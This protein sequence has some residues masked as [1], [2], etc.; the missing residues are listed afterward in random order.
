MNDIDIK[1]NINAKQKAMIVSVVVFLCAII[2]ATYAWISHDFFGVSNNMSVTSVGLQLNFRGTSPQIIADLAPGES[3][4][5]TFQITNLGVAS[6]TVNIYWKNVVNTFPDNHYFMYVLTNADTDEVL[7]SAKYLPVSQ[8][9]ITY[10]SIVPG[11]TTINYNL[12]IT[13]I[14]DPFYD[15]T[16][17]A[18]Y[19]FWG[20]IS[21][22]ARN[23]NLTLSDKLNIYIDGV[24]TDETPDYSDYILDY[25]NSYCT[26]GSSFT[27]TNNEIQL[28][29]ELPSTM[30]SIYLSSTELE[31]SNKEAFN[32]LVI[33]TDTNQFDS[34]TNY[35]YEGEVINL[36]IPERE[37]YA[38]MGW[39]I[40]GNNAELIDNTKIKVGSTYT[41]VKGALLPGYW[42]ER[43]NLCLRNAP[44]TFNRTYKTCESSE[45]GFT[46]TTKT[47]MVSEYKIDTKTCS[48]VT[49]ERK[50]THTCIG[51]RTGYSGTCVGPK[52]V[53]GATSTS[54]CPCGGDNCDRLDGRDCCY[55]GTTTKSCTSSSCPSGYSGTCTS[56]YS[57]SWNSSSTTV[58]SNSCHDSS[59]FTCNYGNRNNSYVSCTPNGW[60]FGNV[61]TTYGAIC[62]PVTRTSCTAADQTNVVC[63]DN[64]FAFGTESVTTAATC[65]ENIIECNASTKNQTYTS[66]VDHNDYAFTENSTDV[67]ANTCNTSNFACDSEHVNQVYNV[68]CEVASTGTGFVSTPVQK[69]YCFTDQSF[70]CDSDQVVNNRYTSCEFVATE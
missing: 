6:Q 12:T 61:V 16:A 18:D 51:T 54:P 66:C 23:I 21:I 69:S 34:K 41:Y 39:E 14:N 25:S 57:Y 65:T 28:V 9:Y 56:Q 7:S 35:Y 26:E 46:K 64:A 27:L 19:Y 55:Q 37:G 48:I 2:G 24:L 62:N 1:V 3:V 63:T 50:S 36:G 58:S 15:Q 22:T 20:D 44:A 70:T 68:S 40:S 30:C 52:L 8:S 33:E 47:C 67:V 43:D 53:C 49:T 29:N 31:E 5:K 11:D 45:A 59:S 4:T 38:F 60:A 13:F 10:Q 32:L 17:N 42:I